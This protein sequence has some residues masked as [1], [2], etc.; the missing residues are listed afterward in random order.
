MGAA[1]PAHAELDTNVWFPTS[2]FARNPCTGEVV[3]VASD[4]HMVI[5]TDE[6]PD[7]GFHQTV[8]LNL[9]GSGVGNQGT[10]YSASLIDQL[11]QN[12]QAGEGGQGEFTHVTQFVVVSHGS[13]CN[14]SEMGVIHVTVNASGQVTG[15]SISFTQ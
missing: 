4:I 10:T 14:I 3:E 1:R 6:N 11:T 13:A 2:V 5:R 12:I 8:H 9:E 15:A 7:G